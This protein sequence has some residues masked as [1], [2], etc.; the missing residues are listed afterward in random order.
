[1]KCWCRSVEVFGHWEVCGYKIHKILAEIKHDVKTLG[2]KQAET[3]LYD[4]FA[5]R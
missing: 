2:R 3:D 1:M 4:N 5:I